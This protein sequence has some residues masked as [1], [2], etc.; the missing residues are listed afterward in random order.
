MSAYTYPSMDRLM[1]SLCRDLV[2]AY[3]EDDML[4][5]YA[6]ASAAAP[7]L[8]PPSDAPTKTELRA[9]TDLLADAFLLLADKR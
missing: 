7:K 2:A 1:R 9:V 4:G 5:V 6:R 8:Y 3:E